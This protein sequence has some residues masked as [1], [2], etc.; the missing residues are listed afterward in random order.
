M[1]I[2][3]NQLCRF[4][5]W[6]QLSYSCLMNCI[7]TMNSFLMQQYLIRVIFTYNHIA[8][9][10]PMWKLI[11]LPLDIKMAKTDIKPGTSDCNFKALICNFRGGGVYV[12]IFFLLLNNKNHQVLLDVV[13]KL[14]FR[15]QYLYMIFESNF[16]KYTN[17]YT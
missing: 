3:R 10:I 8:I 14:I 13:N 15:D 7:T 16:S 5:G 12:K 1:I 6:Q 17:Y 2:W 11:P 4:Y 9:Y